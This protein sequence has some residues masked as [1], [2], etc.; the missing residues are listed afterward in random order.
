MNKNSV[1]WYGPWVAA[2]T[3]FD[4]AGNL[5][6]AAYRRNV[7]LLV[8]YGCTGIVANGCMGEFWAQTFEERC[9]VM[10]LCADTVHS[11]ATVIGGHLG[12]HYLRGHRPQQGRQAGGVRRRA[13]RPALLRQAAG[14]RRRR[15]LPS[16]IRRGRYPD[17][18]LQHPVGGF[19]GAD[20]G[21]GRPARRHRERGRHQGELAR[22]REFLQDSRSGRRP[23]PCVRRAGRSVW[24]RGGDRRRRGDTSKATRTTGPSNRRRS[25]TPPSA[26]TRSWPCACRRRDW[27]C[28]S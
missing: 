25:I 4:A 1:N 6:E 23:H 22:F 15:S 7:D 21:A 24:R 2:V 13:N 28:A 9:R 27:R 17:P 5:D 16:R 18:A 14:G 19:G 26:A 8:D 20:A 11:R 10:E 12:D 3:P